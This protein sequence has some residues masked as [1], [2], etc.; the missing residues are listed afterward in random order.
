[1]KCSYCNNRAI[2]RIL[3]KHIWLCKKCFIRYFESKFLRVLEEVNKNYGLKGKHIVVSTSGGKD[4]LNALY[5]LNKYSDNYGYTVEAIFVN[6][7]IG[8]YRLKTLKTLLDFCQ[9][10]KI[11]YTILDMKKELGYYVSEV[12][13]LY[14]KGKFEYKPCTVCG[15]FR[16]YIVNKYALSVKADYVATGHNLDDEIQTFFMSLLRGDLSSIAREG[17][18]T[19]KSSEYFVPRIKP[20][21]YIYEKESLTYAL[22]MKLKVEPK[23]CPF[24]IYSMRFPIRKFINRLEYVSPGIKENLFK[25]K[26]RIRKYLKNIIKTPKLK[27]CI[28]CGMPTLHDLCRACYFIEL[29]EKAKSQ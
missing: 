2:I 27:R 9:R 1:M 29:I 8:E 12:V 22:L 19:E 17:L 3:H 23:R 5:L 4:S 28:R 20:L 15:V 7:G 6:E 21:Y 26:E 13:E 18:I 10:F 16:R 24:S 14:L 11:D 25:E